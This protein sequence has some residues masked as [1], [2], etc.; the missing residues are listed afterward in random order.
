[1]DLQSTQSL[2]SR[3]DY[4]TVITNNTHY[5]VNTAN[6]RPRW[7]T[8]IGLRGRSHPFPDEFAVLVYDDILDCLSYLMYL[9]SDIVEISTIIHP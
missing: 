6:L 9:N 4:I 3:G 5:Y 8:I 1:M 2:L 7:E